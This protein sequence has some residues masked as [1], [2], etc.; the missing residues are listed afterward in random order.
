MALPLVVSGLSL[1]QRF[2]RACSLLE[3]VGLG[4]RARH[5]PRQLSGGERQRVSLARALAHRPRIIFADEPTAAL[6]QETAKRVIAVFDGIRRQGGTL[7]VASH[8]PE[9]CRRADQVLSLDGGRLA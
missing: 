7:V 3:Q 1:P 4:N 9:I 2:A 5:L 8:D 6:D